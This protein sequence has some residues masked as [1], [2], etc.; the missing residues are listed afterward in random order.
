MYHAVPAAGLLCVELL[1][2]TQAPTPQSILPISDTVQ[3]LSLLIGF[4]DWVKPS[5]PNSELCYRIRDIIRKVLDQVLD[6]PSPGMPEEVVA[7]EFRSEIDFNLRE[8]DDYI[9]FDL[10]DTFDW[11]NEPWVGKIAA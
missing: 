3:N 8:F 1:R 2:N 4:L 9:N 6:S 5:A 11:V 7:W 10:L